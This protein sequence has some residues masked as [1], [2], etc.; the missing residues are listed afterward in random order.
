MNRR[1]LSSLLALTVVLG[2]VGSLSAQ[3]GTPKTAGVQTTDV[4][5][6]T[7][8]TTTTEG[9]CTDCWTKGSFTEGHPIISR[10]V[11]L[12]LRPVGAAIGAPL[13]MLAGF[14]Q[15]GKQ[16]ASVMSEATFGQIKTTEGYAVANATSEIIK[17][18]FLSTFGILGTTLGAT[19]G[20]TMGLMEGTM[21]GT[22]AGFMSPDKF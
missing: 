1:L 21:R 22:A 13:G 19:F 15:G 14:Y 6:T 11:T 9:T 20:A 12:P 16:G 4:V 10:I 18:P 3:A 17:A 7:E 2:A 5:T 8:T